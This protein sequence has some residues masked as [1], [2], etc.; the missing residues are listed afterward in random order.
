MTDLDQALRALVRDRQMPIFAIVAVE[1][2]REEREG[3][4][5]M[6]IL[7]RCWSIVLA[8]V[9]FMPS[10]YCGRGLKMSRLSEN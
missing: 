2:V 5:P 6:D 8:G 10:P 9:P 1:K 4:R 7:P 3:W